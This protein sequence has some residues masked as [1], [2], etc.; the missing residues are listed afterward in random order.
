MSSDLAPPGAATSGYAIRV[1]P[2]EAVASWWSATDAGPLR[3]PVPAGQVSEVECA[4]CL[5]GWR[6]GDP[7]I[8]S[9]SSPCALAYLWRDL[10]DH[11]AHVHGV[12]PDPAGCP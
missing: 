8:W 5:S 4:L 11:L 3:S 6:E 7:P 10:L 9:R 12:R 2:R 1:L